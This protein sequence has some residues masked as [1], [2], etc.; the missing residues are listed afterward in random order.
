LATAQRISGAYAQVDLDTRLEAASPHEL[1]R[2]LL[3]GAILRLGRA[4]E[5]LVNQNIAKKGEEIG[6]VI[7]IVAELQHC[8]VKEPGNDVAR[9][10]NLLYEQI[11]GA[12]VAANVENNLEKLDLASDLLR[13][14]SESWNTIPAE[15]RG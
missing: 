9:N 6:K 5:H 7:S 1:I 15:M 12:I 13:H 10:L 14:L 8:L 3:E 11:M 4:R 2:L